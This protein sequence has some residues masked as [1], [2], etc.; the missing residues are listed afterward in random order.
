MKPNFKTIVQSSMKA[1]PHEGWGQ[2]QGERKSAFMSFFM[3]PFQWENLGGVR[4]ICETQF[5]RKRGGGGEGWRE[6]GSHGGTHEGWHYVWFRVTVN[7][8]SVLASFQLAGHPRLT[9]SGSL[10]GKQD[11]CPSEDS[12]F[13]WWLETFPW[14]PLANLRPLMGI[15]CLCTEDKKTAWHL[16]QNLE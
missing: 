11:A 7:Q 5:E 2:R 14:T 3:V 9:G 12:W 4:Y 8:H 10:P 13:S 6:G 15:W 1:W 16:S